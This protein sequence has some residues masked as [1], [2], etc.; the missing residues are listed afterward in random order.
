MRTGRAA[1][2]AAARAET[3]KL[4]FEYGASVMFILMPFGVLTVL[5]VASLGRRQKLLEG[6]SVGSQFRTI[7]TFALI[8]IPIAFLIRHFVTI[9]A[10]PQADRRR[11]FGPGQ[12][13]REAPA[14]PRGDRP[15]PLGG[16]ADR[17]L[18]AL[19]PGREPG[20][21]GRLEAHARRRLGARG[22]AL[23]RA[24][25]GARRH[26]RRPAR[27]AGPA[28]RRDP[29]LRPDGEDVRRPQRRARAVRD[30]ARVRRARA[31]PARRQQRLGAAA[32]EALRA[33]QVQPPRDRR[34]DEG[35]RDRRPRRPARRARRA[36]G[37]RAAA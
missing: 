13:K 14:G 22:R 26:A 30:P 12:G 4:I 20:R 6:G 17:G 8:A 1:A 7:F 9:H 29:R 28:P 10:Q 15:V 21:G 16:R 2:P 3:P 31:R 24:R 37:A 32:D 23:G 35:R 19:H 27:R 25:R 18:A 33:G 36:R 5:W 11:R 34:D